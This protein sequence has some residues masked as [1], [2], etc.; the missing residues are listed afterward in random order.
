MKY[1]ASNTG[2][3]MPANRASIHVSFRLPQMILSTEVGEKI[4][5]FLVVFCKTVNLPQDQ[6]EIRLKV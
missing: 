1:K 6:S 5:Y 3:T 2:N 4:R